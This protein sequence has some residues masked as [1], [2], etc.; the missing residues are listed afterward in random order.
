MRFPVRSIS[1]AVVVLVVVGF[2][3]KLDYSFWR[4]F[5]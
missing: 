3:L 2:F 4:H 5:S 1:L